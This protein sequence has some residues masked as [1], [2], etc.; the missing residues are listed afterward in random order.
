MNGYASRVSCTSHEQASKQE[1]VT[2]GDSYWYV[3]NHRITEKCLYRY[4]WVLILVNSDWLAVMECVYTVT[5]WSKQTFKPLQRQQRCLNAHTA[6][7][8][9]LGWQL[10][11]PHAKSNLNIDA[12][13]WKKLL[14]VIVLCCCWT[15]P[16]LSHYQLSNA[17][18]KRFQ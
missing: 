18:W 13:H 7:K 15:W 6:A 16:P 14:K 4:I 3:D 9:K 1:G 10:Q 11:M 5:T 17:G 2:S 12:T 8:S